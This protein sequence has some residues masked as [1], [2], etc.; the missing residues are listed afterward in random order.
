MEIEITLNGITRTYKGDYDT[1]Y[2][3]DWDEIIR[4]LIE[5]IV[6]EEK[7]NEKD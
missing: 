3:N 2:N 7:Y 6:S 1:M 5:S 4:D